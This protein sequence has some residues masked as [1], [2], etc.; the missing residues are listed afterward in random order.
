[1][2]AWQY[3]TSK[4]GLEN[5]LQLNANAPI[6]TPSNPSTQHVVQIL[7]TC[8]NPVDYKTAELLPSFLIPKPATPSIDFVGR[9]SKPALGSQMKE[10]QLVFGVAA[11]SPLTGGA[12]AEF[13]I[14]PIEGAAKL[15]EGVSP[16]DAAT[17]GVAGLTAYQ[18]IIPHVKEGDRVFIN[19][20]SGGCGVFGIQIAKAV[21]CHVTTSC[22]TVN[23]DLCTSLGADEVIDYKKGSVL[24]AL[25][26]SG[27]FD[28]V[29]DNV[30]NDHQLYW[31]S[32]EYT[33]K[34]A[35]FIGIAGEPSIRHFTFTTSAK[36]LPGS[37]GGGKRKFMSFLAEP[38]LNQLEQLGSWMAEGKVKAVIDSRFPFEQA[39]DAFKR[40]KTGRAKG[41]IAIDVTSSDIK[42]KE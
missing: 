33:K 27:E 14:S 24:D 36:I 25:R 38:K 40:L 6:P 21:G 29:V 41:K 19:G 39:P 12:L 37:L 32:H 28:H 4:G 35:K 13:S 1:M 9:I 10:G 17:I 15:P 2:K 5:N 34:S 3:Y 7:T 22:S 30:G 16:T 11:L 42:D 8:L 31:K 26:K 23:V 18:A 20:G